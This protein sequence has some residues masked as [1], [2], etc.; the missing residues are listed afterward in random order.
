MNPRLPEP[1]VDAT[2][3][4][5]RLYARLNEIFYQMNP[6][7]GWKDKEGSLNSARVT[8]ASQ[9]T[10]AALTDNIYAWRFSASTLNEVWLNFHIPHD[11]SFT[12]P[13]ED[14]SVQGATLYPH[15]HFSS[16]GT[17]TGTARFGIEYSIARGY[18]VDAFPSSTT[19]YLEQAATGTALQHQ[20]VETTDANA[21]VDPAIET[22]A[23]LLIRL[24][25]DAAHANDTL[26][27][28]VFITFMDLHYYSDGKETNERNRNATGIA[29][30]KKEP[31]E[32]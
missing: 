18:S 5:R 12:Q 32:V 3:Y 20:I 7:E 22:D 15:V 11:I 2:D 31:L 29:W 9:P 23:V 28:A 24:F 26:T 14:G 1:P 16:V 8:G 27:D 21:I 25:R 13:R 10:W 4:E 6:A 19:I 30:T 17:D